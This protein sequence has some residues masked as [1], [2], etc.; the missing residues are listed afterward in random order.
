M[1]HVRSK[2]AKLH[3]IQVFSQCAAEAPQWIGRIY[4]S[5]NPKFVYVP[6]E[7]YD[8]RLQSTQPMMKQQHQNSEDAGKWEP[9]GLPK[10]IDEVFRAIPV[11]NLCQVEGRQLTCTTSGN[12]CRDAPDVDCA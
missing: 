7:W 11:S 3:A 5:E 9:S 4:E 6:C 2:C 8:A 10:S 1:P 12:E